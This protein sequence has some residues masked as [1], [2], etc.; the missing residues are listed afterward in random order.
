MKLHKKQ[1]GNIGE[2]ATTLHLL[3]KGYP[4][5]KELGDLSRAD[6]ITIVNDKCYK[7]QVKN[8]SRETNNGSFTFST[9]KYGPNYT[10]QYTKDDVDIFA[11]YISSIDEVIFLGWDDLKGDT[12]NIRFKKSLNNQ[13]KN[14]NWY[15]DYKDF[16]RLIKP[17]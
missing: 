8:S 17:R 9:H 1:M 11:V 16:E 6:L 13:S 14:V 15:E 2:T 5:F 7:I 3:K 10:F 12:I 4:V